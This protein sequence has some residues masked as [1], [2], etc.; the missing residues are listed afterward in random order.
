VSERQNDSDLKRRPTP[1]VASHTFRSATTNPYA[2][3]EV[4]GS[5]QSGAFVD[6]WKRS[7][8]KSHGRQAD[9]WEHGA[10]GSW[11]PAWRRGY[12]ESIDIST[13]SAKGLAQSGRR[14][15]VIGV[16]NARSVP[17]CGGPPPL[18][19]ERILFEAPFVVAR[20]DANLNRIRRRQGYG[21]REERRERKRVGN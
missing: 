1:P 11:V 21:G 18:C 12:A 5:Q 6:A 15:A 2:K 10:T 7:Q 19:G 9:G 4:F 14:R 17:D 20:M 8:N 16:N 13:M 3:P